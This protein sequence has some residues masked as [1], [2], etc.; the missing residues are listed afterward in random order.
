MR[1]EAT[2][3]VHLLTNLPLLH[4]IDPRSL[5]SGEVVYGSSCPGPDE[6]CF[7]GVL[8]QLVSYLAWERDTHGTYRASRVVPSFEAW[9]P[10]TATA[11]TPVCVYV[12]LVLGHIL[13]GQTCR[14]DCCIVYSQGAPFEKPLRD[15][16]TI[17]ADP[18]C[19]WQAIPCLVPTTC[20][21]LIDNWVRSKVTPVAS[22]W[23]GLKA[24]VSS[25]AIQGEFLTAPDR[26][27][28]PVTLPGF[29][30]CKMHHGWCP[31]ALTG[32][33][34]QTNREHARAQ[35]QAESMLFN[36]AQLPYRSDTK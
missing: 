31:V 34:T 29:E 20:I 23:Y 4:S 33:T 13:E 36:S 3:T 26:P 2:L 25:C 10:S 15:I 30:G 9:W 7:W 8:R 35:L 19:V 24:D 5:H 14:L 27:L 6:H 32:Q 11:L 28:V 17:L 12:Y 1:A 22:L 21:D 16:L 18:V